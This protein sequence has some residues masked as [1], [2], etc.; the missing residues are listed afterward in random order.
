MNE[1]AKFTALT[2]SRCGRAGDPGEGRGWRFDNGSKC[3][4]PQG[5]DRISPGWPMDSPHTHSSDA[6]TL[7]SE[8]RLL[9]GTWKVASQSLGSFDM[10]CWCLIVPSC[11]FLLI[12]KRLLGWGTCIRNWLF[13]ICSQIT[14]FLSVENQSILVSWKNLYL[15]TRQY[16]EFLWASVLRACGTCSW[17]SWPWTP[18][19][20]P[21][22]LPTVCLPRPTFKAECSEGILTK[23]NMTEKTSGI[24]LWRFPFPWHNGNGLGGTGYESTCEPD[25]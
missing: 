16:V 10:L 17:P 21:S 8:H 4:E 22:C 23:D 6:S 2:H 7:P 18:G 15:V 5:F 9:F 3:L 11:S 19:L 20:L 14:V 25:G 1:A 12:M 13:K 24:H